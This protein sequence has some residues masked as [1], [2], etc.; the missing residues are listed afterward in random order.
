[1]SDLKWPDKNNSLAMWARV[2]QAGM[3]ATEPLLFGLSSA[4]PGFNK[5][6]HRAFGVL[7]SAG[8]SA[9]LKVCS[10]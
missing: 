8:S 4:E 10:S 5:C 9:P 3:E 7:P 2:G 1:M 6:K